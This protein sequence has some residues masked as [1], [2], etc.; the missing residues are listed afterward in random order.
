MALL[1]VTA[2]LALGG[3]GWIA[4][5]QRIAAAEI[6]SQ[7]HLSALL[8][9][10]LGPTDAQVNVAEQ[11]RTRELG[12]V[13]ARDAAWPERCVP[14]FDALRTELAT[15]GYTALSR[16]LASISIVGPD[17]SPDTRAMAAI[18]DGA[19][20]TGLAIVTQADSAPPVPPGLL[21][22]DALPS[23]FAGEPR[24]ERF[25]D[26]DVHLLGGGRV[27][28]LGSEAPDLA[29]EA[30][31]PTA[32]DAVV[33]GGARGA[34]P[35]V[36]VPSEAGALYRDGRRVRDGAL[37][38]WTGREGR[39]VVLRTDGLVEGIGAPFAVGEAPQM[40]G[41][42]V[43]ARDTTGAVTV[44]DLEGAFTAPAPTP[45]GLLAPPPD[46]RGCRSGR[47][48]AVE[49]DAAHVAL[50]DPSSSSWQVVEVAPADAE[51][52]CYES[53]LTRTWIEPG[54]GDVVVATQSCDATHCDPVV[55]SQPLAVEGDLPPVATSAGGRVVFV[56]HRRRADGRDLGVWMRLAPVD[57]LDRTHRA[58]IVDTA[59]HCFS[60]SLEA[61]RITSRSNLAATVLVGVGGATLGVTIDPMHGVRPIRYG[62]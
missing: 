27:L 54:E 21:S 10:M 51:L 31:A 19:R 7:E 18:V 30:A 23:L 46:A 29:R 28:T 8:G 38:A 32:S 37:G 25:A 17:G 49:L 35:L 48:A 57:E 22:C 12:A 40:I 36:L 60:G 26:G 5:Q 20:R 61:L 14:T 13:E 53:V 42:F 62:S 34:L 9:C 3:V 56:E 43:F 59:A 33:L 15:T 45:L 39:L 44:R 16:D 4:W 41:P 24:S 47:I 58:V 2:V 50:R 55:R 1:G 6:A 11:L 52:D